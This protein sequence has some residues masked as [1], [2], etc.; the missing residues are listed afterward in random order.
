MS[1]VRGVPSVAGDLG[2]PGH[3]PVEPG[4]VVGSRL[5][6]AVRREIDP[7]TGHHLD[8]TRRYAEAAKLS[9][10]DWAAIREHNA[11]AVY[12]RLDAL[13]RRQGR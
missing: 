5:P 2:D 12:P 8:D 13:L 6:Q 10:E 3:V 7:R 11:R 9:E 4:A 1:L